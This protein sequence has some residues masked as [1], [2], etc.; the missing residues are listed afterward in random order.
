MQSS[1][2]IIRND[3]TIAYSADIAAKDENGEDMPRE[4]QIRWVRQ[5]ALE[6]IKRGFVIGQISYD[7]FQSFDSM[8]ILEAHGIESE[9]VSTDRDPSIWKTLKDIASEGRLKMP[10]E[11]DLLDELDALSRIDGKVDHPPFGCFVGETRIPLLDGTYPTIAELEGKSAYVYSARPDGRIVPGLARGRKTKEVTELV[12]VVLDNGYV[13]RCT[14]EHL[15]MLRDGSYK[16]AIDL[17]PNLDRLMPISW[18]F[19]I[20]GGYV[21][22]TDKDGNRTLVHRLVAEHAANR[23]CADNEVVHH[24]NHVKW[25]NRPANL[26]IMTGVAHT[27]LHADESWVAKTGA[28]RAGHAAWAADEDRKRAMFARRRPMPNERHDVNSDTVLTAIRQGAENVEQVARVLQCS[29]SCVARRLKREGTSFAALVRSLDN[30]HRVRAVISVHLDAPVPVYDLEVDEW[31]NFALTG[32]VFV[33]NSKDMADAFAC[34]IFG[35]VL[36]GGE[37]DTVESSDSSS[38]RFASDANTNELP[39]GMS[40]MLGEMPYGFEGMAIGGY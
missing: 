5:L 13:A 17:Q 1:V 29:G 32:G 4:I 20:G 25:D 36:L 2:P 3:F 7:S 14:P 8:Q 10:Q 16:R 38:G 37:E 28:F 12:D 27:K 30:N 11:L 23:I 35:A 31:D 24:K 19:P 34:S 33:H 39:F 15:W 22:V 40:G 26:E 21:R 6:L 18:A 9:R